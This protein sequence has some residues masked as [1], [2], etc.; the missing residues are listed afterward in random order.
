M[1]PKAL[2]FDVDGT[3]ADTEEQHRR[4]FN[5]AFSRHGFDW[6]WSAEEYKELLRVTGGKERIEYFI[7]SLNLSSSREIE[8]LSEVIPLHKTKNT[9][10][11]HS[12]LSGELRL[13]SGVNR[14]ILEALEN[15]IRLAIAT[16]TSLTNVEVLLTSTLGQDSI[17]WFDS[18]V[19]GDMVP[20]KKPSPDVYQEALKQ[21][22]LRAMEC[23]AF[24]DSRNGLL[25]AKQAGIPCVVTPCQW[26]EDHDFSEACL[27]LPE[28]GD[29]KNPLSTHEKFNFSHPWLSVDDLARAQRRAA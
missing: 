7:R 17:R 6:Q 4:A 2:I 28:L 16:T 25:S 10:Y 26:T 22:N 3:L 29:D 24:E 20:N 11:S 21:L 19:A 27:L 13:R 8:C 18:I 14:I 9:L 23:V 5:G 1:T 12:I 15:G